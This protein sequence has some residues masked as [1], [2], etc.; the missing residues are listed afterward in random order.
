MKSVFETHNEQLNALLMAGQ[1]MD[2]FERYYAGEVVMQENESEPRLGKALNRGQCA[3]FVDA[4]P[5]L[6]MTVLQTAY[7][8]H[9]SMQEVQFRYTDA[10]GSPVEY[11]EVA[12]RHWENGLIVR[13]K[14][15]YAA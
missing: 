2:A 9:V 12:V 6:V 4:H 7:G 5:D 1:A 10:S 13:E 11:T 14:F 8:E 15:Y 3:A